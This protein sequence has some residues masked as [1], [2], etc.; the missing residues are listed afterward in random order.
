MASYVVALKGV[1]YIFYSPLTSQADTKLWQV[2]PTI[3]SGDFKVSID[4]GAYNN[5]STLPVVTPA[6]GTFVKFTLST[7]E[8][9]GDN[10]TVQGIDAAGAEWCGFAALIPTATRQINDLAFPTT[11]GRGLDVT[12]GG[13]AGIDWANVEAPTTAVNLSGTN[14]KTDQVVASVTG[15]VGSVTADVSADIV[16]INGTTV[17]G[18]GSLATPWSP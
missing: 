14:I 13:N 15:A 17:Q 1:E 12:A 3:A 9:D 11:S 8:M 5:L 18:D 6:G 10:I 4:G 7:S 16:S 2:N